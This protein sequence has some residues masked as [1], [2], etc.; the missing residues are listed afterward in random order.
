MLASDVL[1]QGASSTT[2]FIA[3]GGG[4]STTTYTAT[5]PVRITIIASVAGSGNVLVNGG[6]MVNGATVEPATMVV[7]LGASQGISV[8]AGATSYYLI[9]AE[10]VN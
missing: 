8:T 6:S 3:N 9:S 5:G 1:K 2:T 7:N 10:K 4:G